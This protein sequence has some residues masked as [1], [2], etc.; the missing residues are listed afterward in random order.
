MNGIF[1]HVILLA[2]AFCC[3]TPAMA[4]PFDT[5]VTDSLLSS[6][7]DKGKFQG[8]V[9]LARDGKVLYRKSLGLADET[10]RTPL[11][12]N[13]VFELASCSKQFTAMGI[14]LLHHQGKL[15]YD[16]EV[17]KYI[18]EL[19]YYKG[20]TLKHLIYHTSGLPDYMGLEDTV[21]AHWDTS[22]IATNIDVIRLFYGSKPALD[23]QPGTKHAYSNTGYLLLA[24]VIEKVSGKTYGDYLEQYIFKPLGMKNTFVYNRRYAPRA[25]KNYASGYVMD[26]AG[27]RKVLPDSTQRFRYVYTL[28]GI[29]GDG[30]VN[31]T[32]NDL[33][34]WD[35]ALYTEKLL[36]AAERDVLFESGKLNDGT[37]CSYGFGWFIKDNQEGGKT[38]SH[39]GSWPGYITYIERNI[40]NKET[41]II[42]QNKKEVVIPA[43]ELRLLLQGKPVPAPEV[44]KEIVVADSI[45]NTYIGDYLLDQDFVLSIT[46]EKN[47]LFAQ[48]T[49]QGK[50]PVYPSSETKFFLKVVDAQMEFVKT[51]AVV[52]EMLFYQNGQEIKAPKI[53]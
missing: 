15:S 30:M 3:R 32:V 2:L 43:K 22:K 5:R 1:L 44:R 23:F 47:Q 38:L 9:L 18:P 52:K 27:E 24:S 21:W 26:D 39:S 29:V 51:D 28:D 31:S 33:L 4:Q 20:I 41:L 6:L 19:D 14:A 25:I 49:G 8:N 7:Y 34:K 10:T 12:D 16:D 48:A 40:K 11:N 45:L 13:S 17:R 53:K 50:L 37:P 46:R 35:Q 36:P 42:L